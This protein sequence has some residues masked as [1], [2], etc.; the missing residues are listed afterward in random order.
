MIG[1]E[2]R[3]NGCTGKATHAVYELARD[4]K[5]LVYVCRECMQQ[6][7]ILKANPVGKQ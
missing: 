6:M 1:C 3:L 4:R 5:P 2:L 7:S